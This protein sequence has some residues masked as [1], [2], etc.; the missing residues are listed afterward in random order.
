MGRS[1]NPAKRAQQQ[2]R[3]RLGGSPLIHVE[4]NE[5]RRLVVMYVGDQPIG[6]A[7]ET[8]DALIDSLTNANRALRARDN[9]PHSRACGIGPHEHGP[10]CHSNCPTCG[11][12]PVTAA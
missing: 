4:I 7:P 8:T 9:R 10:A 5:E 11:G 1:G 2:A 6:M 12:K 3:A